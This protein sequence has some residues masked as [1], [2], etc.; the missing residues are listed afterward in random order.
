MVPSGDASIVDGPCSSVQSIN[1]R[2]TG[3]KPPFAHNM[4]YPADDDGQFCN[5]QQ[6]STVSAP[7]NYMVP[8]VDSSIVVGPSSSDQSI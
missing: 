2:I 4:F 1:R 6:T 7:D 5:A 3:K 8:F